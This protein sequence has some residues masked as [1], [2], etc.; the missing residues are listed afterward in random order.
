MTHPHIDDKPGLEAYRKE[1]IEKI[2]LHGGKVSDS[3]KLVD[4][5]KL[6]S[7]TMAKAGQ[8]P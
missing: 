3:A 6:Y 7:D 8:K 2:R 1:L 4:V 5:K